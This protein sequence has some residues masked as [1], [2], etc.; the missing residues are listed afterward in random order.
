MVSRQL[1]GGL[2]PVTLAQG[3]L[4]HLQRSVPFDRAA[5]Y[6]RS[7]G[8]RLTPIA[9]EGGDRLDWNVEGPLFD[10]AWAASALV[11]RDPP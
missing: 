8:G 10:E 2:D 4:E 11:R 1:S 9:F 3:L 5:V 7:N 6:V